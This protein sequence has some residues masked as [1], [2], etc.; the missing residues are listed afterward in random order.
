MR[1]L[2]QVMIIVVAL[3]AILAH[4]QMV[5]PTFSDITFAKIDS[6]TELKL[7]LYLPDGVSAPYPLLIW[8][9]G[10]AW[11][12]GDKREIEAPL[13]FIRWGYAVASIEYRFSHVARWPAQI[14]DVKA[15][16]RWLRA[17]GAEYQIDTSHVVT[18]GGS[19][20]AHLSLMAALTNGV[21]EFEGSIGENLDKS[22]H[23]D[24]AINY[25]GHSDFLSLSPNHFQ[26]SSS[27][28]QLLGCTILSC[29]DRAR[30]ASPITYID[31][32]DPPIITFHGTADPTVP[33]GQAIILDSLLRDAGVYTSVFP[34]HMG[35][36]GGHEF[37]ADST[38]GRIM[39]FLQNESNP[40]P[41]SSF[42]PLIISGD[43][44][45]AQNGAIWNYT[46]TS[47]GEVYELS[48][49]MMKPKGEGPF[50]AVML[51]HGMGASAKSYGRKMG[52]IFN[53]WGYVVFAINYTHS[54]FVLCGQPGTCAV[55]EYGASEVNV[56][57]GIKGWEVLSKL[58]FVDSTR[59]MAF[60]H[61]RG[62]FVTTALAAALGSR[63]RAAAHT[64]GGVV[65]G[66]MRGTAPG[67]SVALRV[68]IPYQIHHGTADPSIPFRY[69][70]RLDSLLSYT[71]TTH[72]FFK[73]PRMNNANMRFD[74]NMLK[75]VKLWFDKYA[76]I[77]KDATAP[78]VHGKIQL[79]GKFVPSL[80]KVVLSYSVQSV[81]GS[82][83]AIMNLYGKEVRSLR[84]KLR[85]GNIYW[86][87]ANARGVRQPHGLYMARLYSDNTWRQVLV[88]LPPN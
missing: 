43:P 59:V 51:N 79:N 9:H 75:R 52:K 67:D 41:D 20:G 65:P 2:Y 46:D 33:F 4:G 53:S 15:A 17:H 28:G 22:S 74:Q 69:A 27:T 64:S 47:N 88:N 84:I 24:A 82:R 66:R 6:S 73:Y 72:V 42:Y 1:I 55:S 12:M 11:R 83:M 80:D 78:K 30:K 5:M 19:A 77:A 23:V 14:Y 29:P 61:G 58:P 16:I 39:G 3:A 76:S 8:I 31:H 87:G 85:A 49:M 35:G 25:F 13:H 68:T 44:E 34:I 45:D 63:I 38:I 54:A 86:D 81:K 60:G 21:S 56:K 48:G 37:E 57:R 62:A 7:D 18:W 10:G 32:D 36:H 70:K 50:P 40:Y 26:S 71:G